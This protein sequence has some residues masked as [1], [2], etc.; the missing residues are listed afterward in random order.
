M[1]D[2]KNREWNGFTKEIIR[3]DFTIFLFSGSEF[4]VFPH[5]GGWNTAF[6]PAVSI[7]FVRFGSITT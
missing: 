1:F 2:K 5:W 4:F 7:R 6:Q 3:V